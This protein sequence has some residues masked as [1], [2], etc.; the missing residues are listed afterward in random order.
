MAALA[1]GL[2]QSYYY[3]EDTMEEANFQMTP[4]DLRKL[5]GILL[6]TC[7]PADPLCLWNFSYNWMTEDWIHQ[8]YQNDAWMTNQILQIINPILLQNGLQCVDLS[9]PDLPRY[10]KSVLNSISNRNWMLN[11]E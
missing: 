2:L 10:D 11:E 1:R 5:F 6:A 7:Q 4:H 9:F 8:G 3:L